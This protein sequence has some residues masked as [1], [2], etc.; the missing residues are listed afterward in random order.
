MQYYTADR[1]ERGWE[2]ASHGRRRGGGAVRSKS[3]IYSLGTPIIEYPRIYA[4]LAVNNDKNNNS[5]YSEKIELTC[6]QYFH[7]KLQCTSIWVAFGQ[8]KEL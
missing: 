3:D 2:N 1:A 6:C 4:T 8:K 5:T 7:T